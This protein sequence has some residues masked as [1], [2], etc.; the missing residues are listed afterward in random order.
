MTFLAN[1]QEIIV[2]KVI[3]SISNS[4]LPYVNIGILGKATGTV[5][6]KQG[7]F[8]L[9]LN[10]LINDN[11]EVIFELAGFKSVSYKVSSLKEKSVIELQKE[12][13]VLDEVVINLKKGKSQKLG[14]KTWG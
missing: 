1:A 3:D 12:F 4:V 2:G 8:T 6:D 9:K 13:E 14:K 7:N 11:D 10:N 5:S